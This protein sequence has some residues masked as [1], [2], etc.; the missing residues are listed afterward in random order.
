ML[1]MFEACTIRAAHIRYQHFPMGHL[2]NYN[3]IVAVDADEYTRRQHK[4]QG[5]KVLHFNSTGFKCHNKDDFHST[6]LT[7]CLDEKALLSPWLF[8][9]EV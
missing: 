3:P 8:V 4:V 5:C 6:V 9:F 1:K 2:V 7:N